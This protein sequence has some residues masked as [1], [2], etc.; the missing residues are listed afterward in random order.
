MGA[1]VLSGQSN[2]P[3]HNKTPQTTSKLGQSDYSKTPN[4]IPGNVVSLS[5]QFQMN[6]TCKMLHNRLFFT[7]LKQKYLNR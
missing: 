1:C 6:K 2:L 3:N 5:V 7:I 4:D